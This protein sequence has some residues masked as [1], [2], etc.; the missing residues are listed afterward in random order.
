MPHAIHLDRRH[1]LGAAAAIAGTPFD[2]LLEAAHRRRAAAPS[3]S[4]F[5]NLKQIDAGVLN[6][7]TLT[8][9]LLTARR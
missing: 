4:A 5:S 7:A 9:V 8:S 3:D 6:T 2:A 1:F